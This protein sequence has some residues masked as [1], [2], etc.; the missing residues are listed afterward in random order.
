M[1]LREEF[2][3]KEQRELA[4]YAMTSVATRGRDHE[5][6]PDELRTEFQRDR[7]R[8]IHSKAFRRLE[9]KTQ[10]FVVHEGDHYRTR[11]THTL[12]VSQVGET[13][14]RALGLNP[15]LTETIALGHDLGHTPFGHTGEEALDRILEDGFRHYEQGVRVVE[16]L[17][18]PYIYKG[19]RGLN[20]TWE[21]REGILKNNLWK[22]EPIPNRDEFAHLLVDELPTLEAQVIMYAD[23]IAFI[24]HDVDDGLRSG[25]IIVDELK[26]LTIWEE[27][28]GGPEK[29]ASRNIIPFLVNDVIRNSK[30]NLKRFNVK[31]SEDAKRADHLI[32]CFSEST[33]RMKEELFSYLFDHVYFHHRVARI[34]HKCMETVETLFR[35]FT[36]DLRLLPTKTQARIK[37][38]IAALPGD[39]SATE[40]NAAE[41]RIVA[42]TIRDYIA[43]MTDR[44]AFKVYN[45]LKAPELRYT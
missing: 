14:A 42:H 18:T 35:E 17:E 39:L 34:R 21:T 45:D 41:R 27:I 11:L 26:D 43:G 13:I 6:A 7:D 29:P 24:S 38:E 36:N 23:Q 40:H 12:E 15:D 28:Q 2:E 31:T 1:T 4:P 33:R 8:I 3:A 16:Y 44:Y 20:L 32:V 5:I 10:V 25:L 37:E 22:G 19:H 30:E 9:Y